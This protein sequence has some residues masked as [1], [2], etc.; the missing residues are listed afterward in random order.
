MAILI[1]FEEK[2]DLEVIGGGEF[3]IC[4]ASWLEILYLSRIIV[5]RKLA[6]ENL[7]VRFDVEAEKSFLVY[8][9]VVIEQISSQSLPEYLVDGKQLSYI[10]GYLFDAVIFCLQ[11]QGSFA[12]IN[13][14]WL[15]DGTF[16]L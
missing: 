9:D 13:I 7:F 6:N 3:D 5:M 2:I 4:D 8:G 1:D 12:P 14:D 10:E 11:I 15:L 16:K